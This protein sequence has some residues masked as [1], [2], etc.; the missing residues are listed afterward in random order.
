MAE[1]INMGLSL[2]YSL[3]SVLAFTMAG[4]LFGHFVEYPMRFPHE[5]FGVSALLIILQWSVWA[6]SGRDTKREKILRE[7]A[8]S[9]FFAS[10][11]AF[12][13]IAVYANRHP[14]IIAGT[15]GTFSAAYLWLESMALS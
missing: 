5:I 14:L 8:L 2:R 11:S 9:L 3:I 15:V 13:L 1:L 10:F 7:I 12:S 4:I 6:I